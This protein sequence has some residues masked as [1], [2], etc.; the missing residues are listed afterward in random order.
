MKKRLIVPFC[1]IV[2]S[3]ILLFPFHFVSAATNSLKNITTDK[4]GSVK[5]E[6]IDADKK[7]YKI[8]ITPKDGYY[9]DDVRL[10]YNDKAS[11]EENIA[12]FE[13]GDNNSKIWYYD[14][15]K[16]YDRQDIKVTFS[17]LDNVGTLKLTAVSDH[18]TYGEDI[19][20]KIELEDK[21]GKST[22]ITDNGVLYLYAPL[23]ITWFS[24]TYSR[25]YYEIPRDNVIS[26]D[27]TQLNGTNDLVF[28][29]YY[30]DRNTGFITDRCEVKVNIDS[31]QSTIALED[32]IQTAGE[33]SPVKAKTSE[34]NYG[35]VT[36][37][38]LRNNSYDWTDIVPQWPGTYNMKAKYSGSKVTDSCEAT[39]TLTV[40]ESDLANKYKLK[41]YLSSNSTNNYIHASINSKTLNIEG[42]CSDPNFVGYYINCNSAT[43]DYVKFDGDQRTFN[44]AISLDTLQPGAYD[45]V[46]S[47]KRISHSGYTHSYTAANLL[48]I[49]ESDE[50][51][52]LQSKAYEI[53]KNTFDNIDKVKDLKQYDISDTQYSIIS[54]KA[55]EITASA[56]DDYEKM[57]LL[58]AWVADTIY[59]DWDAFF[60]D[61]DIGKQ[62]PFTVFESKKSVCMGYS[63]LLHVMLQ[64]VGIKDKQIFGYA[65]QN[66][67]YCGFNSD[68]G[69]AW[70]IAYSTAQNRWI[71]IDATWGSLN[72]YE[73]GKAEYTP[74]IF[75]WFDCSL[76][77]L[78]TNHTTNHPIDEKTLTKPE[79]IDSS[80]ISVGDTISYIKNSVVLQNWT[81]EESPSGI[82]RSG[83]NTDLKAMRAGVCEVKIEG[84]VNGKY[85]E[86]K[87]IITVQDPVMMKAFKTSTAI[88]LNKD[89]KG[90]LSSGKAIKY[91]SF[92]SNKIANIYALQFK[93]ASK[94]SEV[95][96]IVYDKNGFE[97]TSLDCEPGKNKSL[98]IICEKNTTYYIKVYTEGLNKQ[99]K[100]AIK[101]KN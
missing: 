92:K 64:S 48:I 49:V 30:Q 96:C 47:P 74:N 71:I 15:Q 17:K 82:L 24:E 31:I 77:A 73:D 83:L 68:L 3:I 29:G 84:V 85:Y 99:L 86:K 37:E 66:D 35:S 50:I 18:V 51:Y 87:I 57:K 67:Y 16:Y 2:L 25:Q 94:K 76:Q 88:F 52:F 78:S 32:S 26:I 91:Y 69:H 80:T 9:V 55:K 53:N 13:T 41:D 72:T 10:Y 27:S 43:S 61:Y 4:N 8:T 6:L 59:Y 44:T 90:S 95:T 63:N 14:N 23:D 54:K 34:S 19:K 20:I 22:K 100:Y 38:V 11:I 89:M 36:Y 58:Y 7:D 79:F 21:N 62:N 101:I 5:V 65:T 60:D 12:V 70:N 75:A 1:F 93:N 40:K 28:S 56:I 42:A 45:L 81:L 33:V 39:A 98:K 97:M 46:V